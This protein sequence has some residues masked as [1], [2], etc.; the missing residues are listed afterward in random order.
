[1]PVKAIP[2][3]NSV[4]VD[5]GDVQRFR[6]LIFPPM[7]TMF[8]SFLSALCFCFRSRAFLQF[9]SLALRHQINVLRRSGR[10]RLRL[11]CADRLLWVGLSRL[12]KGWCSVLV[13]V[14]PETVIRW[15]RTG[16]R[17]Y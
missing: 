14:K 1:M 17:L 4:R 10:R 13:I 7:R 15:H 3:K 5:L 16:F 9:E 11:S 6:L 2:T 8:L 12:W